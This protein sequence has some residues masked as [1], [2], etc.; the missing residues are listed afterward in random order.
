MMQDGNRKQGYLLLV[1]M[2]SEDGCKARMGAEQR[3]CLGYAVGPKYLL[4]HC[5]KRTAVKSSNIMR[6]CPLVL[7]T[8]SGDSI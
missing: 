2:Q 7:L 1:R 4:H 8:P 5:V 3:R 6:H